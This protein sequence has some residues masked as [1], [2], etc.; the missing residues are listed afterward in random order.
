MS[1]MTTFLL[2]CSWIPIMLYIADA[3]TIK[4]PHKKV[5][6]ASK[7][8]MCFLQQIFFFAILV[9]KITVIVVGEIGPFTRALWFLYA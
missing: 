8:I 4:Y 2:R 7:R 9:W 5:Y 6:I 1:F 3:N